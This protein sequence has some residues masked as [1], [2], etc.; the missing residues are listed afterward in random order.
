MLLLLFLQLLVG[1]VL[2]LVLLGG[3]ITITWYLE[4]SLYQP[5]TN[6]DGYRHIM[7]RYS[8]REFWTAFIAL[9]WSLPFILVGAI[10]QVFRNIATNLLLLF[11]LFLIATASFGWL[12]YHDQVAR[13]Y[14][15]GRQCILMP[16]A[17][18]FAFPFLNAIRIVYN[19]VIMLW[20]YFIDL[21]K[22]YSRG[23]LKIFIKCTLNTVDVV[24]LFTYFGNIFLVF[25]RD[26]EAFLA[27]GIFDTDF[28][29]TNT[30]EAIGLFLDT[31]V[32]PLKCFCRALGF[33]WDALSVWLQ[34]P[35]LHSTIN[36]IFNFFVTL[37]QIPFNVA[38]SFPN[39]RPNFEKPTLRACCALSSFGTFVE[40]TLFIIL[41]TG[42]GVFSNS[43]LPSEVAL[44][45]SCPWAHTLTD[46]VCGIVK[47]VN[48]TLTATV[49]YDELLASTGIGYLQFGTIFDEFKSAANSLSCLMLLFN[50]DAQATLDQALLS[51]INGV[52]FLFE[53]IPG[54]I[55][56][57]LYG[58][59][60]PLYP[61]APF[62][63]YVNFLEFY[64]P[65]YWLKPF[66]DNTINNSTYVYSSALDSTFTS[67][68]MFTQALGNLIGN[69][70]DMDP[71]GGIIQHTL[72][73]IIS[74]VRILA[75]LIS[76]I[77]T[78]VTFNSDI[79]TTARKVDFDGLF[80]EMYFLAG[81]SGDFFRQ[82]AEPDPLTN[83]TCVVSPTES[84]SSVF[85][86]IGK[87]V[88]RL[89]DAL[90]ATL[91]QIVHF[92]Q[93]LLTLPTGNV[94]LCV[95]FIPYNASNSENC[96]RI[97]NFATSI[98]LLDESLCALSCAA[99]GVI[100]L[101][102][103]FQCSFPLPP[104]STNPNVP[105]EPVKPC[106]HVNTCFGILVCRVL[107]V[108]LIPFIILNTM[109]QT[110]LS[111]TYQ[112]FTVLGTFIA[113]VVFDVFADAVIGLGLFINCTLCSF[114]DGGIN[115]DDS[116]YQLFV[117]FAEL[118]R[119]IPIILET[120]FWIVVKLIVAFVI[121]IFGGDP[122]G[123]VIDFV[124]GIL[125]DL[126]NG[127]GK[128]V[129][130]F[131]ARFFDAIGLGFIGTFI[132]IL[133]Q[134]FCPLLQFIL[135]AIIVVLKILTFG[136]V[137]IDFVEFCCDGNPQCQPGQGKRSSDGLYDGVINLNV[138]RLT[139]YFTQY[140]RWEPSNPCNATMSLYSAYN[141]TDLTEWQQ[142]EVLFCLV[143]P[144]WKI[145]TDNQSVM[146]NS[147]CDVLV[148]EYNFTDWSRIDILTRRT[149]IDCMYSR[150]FV[151][152]FRNTAQL[153][154]IPSDILTNPYRKY[155]FGAEFARGLLIYW[156]YF[157]DRSV[158]AETFVSSIYQNNW[159][160]M[161]L[162]IDHYRGVVSTDD[163]LIFRD[164]YKLIDYFQWN[165]ATQYEAVRDISLGTWKF[166]N[167]LVDSIANV[168]NAM[169]DSQVD[170]TVYLTFDYTLGNSAASITSSMYALFG[171]FIAGAKNITAYWS[172]PAN[173]K[174]RADA[175]TLL[176]GGTHGMYKAMVNELTRIGVDYMIVKRNESKYWSGNCSV[177]EGIKFM[178]EYNHSLHHDKR[179]S[180]YRLSKWYEK[181]KATLFK[182]YKISNPREGDRRV[183]YNQS[184]TLFQ[185]VDSD[186]RLKDE[187]GRERFTRIISSMFNGTSLSNQRWTLLSN[188]YTV[189]KER[190]YGA[191][192]RNNINFAKQYI[193]TTMLKRV[194]IDE[195]SDLYDGMP[196]IKI[197]SKPDEHVQYKVDEQR[198]QHQALYCHQE[199]Y[200]SDGL[201]HNFI[202]EPPATEAASYYDGGLLRD[203]TLS[204]FK[205][206]QLQRA[207]TQ[208]IIVP[209][210]LSHFMR[211]SKFIEQAVSA[212]DAFIELVCRTNISFS[213]STLCEECFYLDQL[214]GRVETGLEWVLAYYNDGQ[215]NASLQVALDFFQY[216]F[217]D[218][219]YVVVGD[220]P[221]L[222]PH[223]FPGRDGTWWYNTRYFGD[224]V[225]NKTRFSD[226]SALFSRINN[227]TNATE[228][229]TDTLTDTSFI[230]GVVGN[231]ILS[232]FGWFWQIVADVFAFFSVS[233]ENLASGAAAEIADFFFQWLYQCDWFVG[234][235]VSGKVIRFSIG[236]T[237]LIFFAFYVAV[238]LVFFATI[239]VNLL[240]LFIFTAIGMVV[241]ISLFL[242]ISY[243]M[244]YACY[245]ALPAVLADGVLYFIYYS[246]LPK[247]MWFWSFLIKNV[248]YD[249]L[250]CFFCDTAT[251]WE[252]LNCVIDQGFG[253]IFSN[254]IFMIQFYAP[255]LLQWIRDST[256]LPVVLFYQIPYVNQRI[257][258]FATIDMS[259]PLTYSQYM[260]CNYIVTILPNFYIGILFLYLLSIVW[261][262][263]V[264]GLIFIADLFLLLFRF[265][266]MINAMAGDLFI[267]RTI[268]PFTQ[269]G[270]MDTM[271]PE[272]IENE[273][274]NEVEQQDEMRD[275]SSNI[276]KTRYD[277]K[278][279]KFSFNTLQ[280]MF[281]RGWDNLFLTQRKQK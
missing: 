120:T 98:F 200:K 162:N 272:T 88:E 21:Q 146:M 245:P 222:S 230:N 80:N 37:A 6:Y 11:F 167:T 184:R 75:N 280:N 190:L 79:R 243:N 159:A 147:T 210:N 49:H 274:E 67:L 270:L 215:F 176:K 24:N 217:D 83:L 175:M 119:Y 114:F 234:D 48:L 179:S 241:T 62:G 227:G 212:T 2:A 17:Y 157:K 107:R 151:D 246:L 90:T 118:L 276:K 224:N 205:T 70:L 149:I 3:I 126:F 56:Y 144:Y 25:V 109:V 269:I 102:S 77:F 89:L 134:G 26:L 1:G 111:G 228:A 91:Q 172:N 74:L 40:D 85:C 42:W 208:E 97:P 124:I 193:E 36:C 137:E 198:K 41:E 68:F 278:R 8:I 64:F 129:V 260:G 257:N 262:L 256:L 273:E 123:A 95:Q 163:I 110:A 169:S 5:M 177:E 45:A 265:L 247:C 117:S 13:T 237:I 71:L 240:N 104:P 108:F 78:I 182:T 43:A 65:D 106:G 264:V 153:Q 271:T 204:P 72:N 216:S 31:F 39:A 249:N 148:V 168:T 18:Y 239:Q 92:L 9:F 268:A 50:N 251:R 238:S 213:N 32:S 211:K 199:Q 23:A 47:L 87:L 121:G 84:E 275:F 186:G 138:N 218:N 279:S 191:V 192:I 231:I 113:K 181:N 105:P 158:T 99:L 206:M 4:V 194:T 139:Q 58:G 29:I 142:N 156:Q 81:S 93:D 154:W 155:V 30:L 244:G 53:W 263:V 171:Q 63:S 261:P 96:L 277:A 12:Q 33:L 22:F 136:L 59:P 165:S 34:L 164:R 44:L 73:I 258:A 220:S 214:I 160:G 229:Q 27:G 57:Y 266:R 178:D 101:I 225:P 15:I 161:G 140:V 183:T 76:F 10:F 116:I 20:N 145:R 221:Q 14:L 135:N 248:E 185:Y 195:L 203:S 187:T 267:T 35:S 125:T 152:G 19:A 254:I 69:L 54:N 259:D 141:F 150:L 143:K 173:V 250:T 170:P 236:E 201:C 52:A 197:V 188:I 252:F 82:F 128:A 38:I 132:R 202:P 232:V 112:T 166:L 55:W 180:V 28:D 46:P 223:G 66:F 219:A 100:P 130:D 235:D 7:V 122:I 60:L 207:A 127:L 51:I 189:T 115:C 131:L 253:D 133:W 16:I 255:E 196:N 61:N 94:I 233:S 174:K 226:I 281:R 209:G 103:E 86:C 242:S